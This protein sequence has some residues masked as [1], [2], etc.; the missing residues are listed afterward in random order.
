MIKT[1]NR[2]RTGN[3]QRRGVLL[4]VVMVC[5]LLVSMIGGSLLK[6]G[7]AQRRQMRREQ[8]RQQ[9]IWLAESGIERAVARLRTD[10]EYSG[11][12]WKLDDSDSIRGKPAVVKISVLRDESTG[13]IAISVVADYPRDTDQRVRISKQVEVGL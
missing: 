7:L 13:K 6:L 2:Q 1:L 4:L 8:S 9:A 5:L 12:D 10:S 11:E 3:H